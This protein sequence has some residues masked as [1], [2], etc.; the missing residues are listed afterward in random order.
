MPLA[1]ARLM[2][3]F[4]L[5]AVLSSFSCPCFQRS[6]RC[7]RS[8]SRG[9]CWCRRRTQTGSFKGGSQCHHDSIQFLKITPVD[10]CRAE[11]KLG[12]V[13]QVSVAAVSELFG[14]LRADVVHLLKRHYKL[15]CEIITT[16]CLI[17]L[18]T[19]LVWG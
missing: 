5:K 4:S 11:L 3:S 17:Y 6:F 18:V 10:F 1:V 13:V 7:R 16:G 2:P 9:T 15:N 19:N 14:G 12:L 8:A